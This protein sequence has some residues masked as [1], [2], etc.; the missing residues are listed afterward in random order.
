MS[1][2]RTWH[3]SKADVD[4]LAIGLR[5]L[6]SQLSPRDRHRVAEEVLR[7]RRARDLGW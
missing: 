4:R 6:I 3:P 5:P 7:R 1:Q 2:L